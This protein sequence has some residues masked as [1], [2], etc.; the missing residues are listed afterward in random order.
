MESVL[1]KHKFNDDILLDQQDQE[2][3]ARIYPTIFHVLD[4]PEL[5]QLFLVYDKASSL[6][7]RKGRWAGVFAIAFG[8]SALAIAPLE[9]PLTRQGDCFQNLIS[10]D[11]EREVLAALSAVFGIIGVVIGSIGVLFSRKKREWLHLRLMT[12][13]IRQFHFQTLVYRMP[14]I[15]LSL[16]GAHGKS[17]FVSDRSI[18]FEAFKDRWVGKLDSKFTELIDEERGPDHWLHERQKMLTK[19]AESKEL[20]PLF[21]AYRELRIVHQIGIASHKLGHDHRI[22]SAIPRRQAAVFA[23]VSTLWIILLCFID[24][25]VIMGVFFQSWR[26]F[27]SAGVSVVVIFIALAALATRA[28]EQGLQPER[29]VERYQQY[30]SAVRAVLERFDDAESQAEKIQIMEEMER[31]SF[32]ELRNFLMTNDRAH[33]VI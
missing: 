22:F 30:R 2:L 8:F 12:E 14:E 15:L 21:V 27:N 17:S 25:C 11:R 33:F 3:A 32:D 24:A 18:W 5:R 13:R 9:Y 10:C 19:I 26:V 4:H 1:S 31:L 16:K 23:H 28:F 6:A 20:E 29:E 7:K